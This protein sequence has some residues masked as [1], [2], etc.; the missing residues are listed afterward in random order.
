MV[1]FRP[2]GIQ[3]LIG[4]LECV[5]VDPTDQ[6]YEPQAIVVLCHGFGAPGTDLVECCRTMWEL[7][8]AELGR[9]RFVFP[10]GPLS[11]DES[12]LYDARAW[13]PIDME[14]LNEMMVTGEFR[15]L[16]REKPEL[17]DTRREQVTALLES[18]L[19]ESALDPASLILGGF[20][21]GSMLM[22]DVALRLSRPP[23]GL[24]VWS[25]TLLNESEWRSA[26]SRQAKFP[27]FQSHGRYDSI[28]PFEAARW[29]HQ[30]FI[31][32]G[33]S[34]DFVPF[35]GLHEIPM[36]AMRGAAALAARVAQS[37]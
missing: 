14:R 9:T 13:W 28:L 33:F 5:V 30:L 29:L 17:L 32:A 4:E 21:Q 26:A 7:Q 22:T 20:S 31:D 34:A 36:P 2:V 12:G 19:A 1:T 37:H 35:D 15:D 8:R 10:A 24:I 3:R 6:P 16:R 23:G 27:V 25:G 18:L 11:L